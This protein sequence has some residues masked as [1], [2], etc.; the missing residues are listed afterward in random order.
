MKLTI[1]YT[2]A[3]ASGGEWVWVVGVR[4]GVD[5]GAREGGFSG[6]LPVGE[7]LVRKLYIVQSETLLEVLPALPCEEVVDLGIPGRDL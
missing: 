4:R 6:D 7:L 3:A 1:F 5:F 2:A